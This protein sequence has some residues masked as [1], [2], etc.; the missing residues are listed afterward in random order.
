MTTDPLP[1]RVG[2]AGGARPRRLRPPPRR[3]AQRAARRRGAHRR[4]ARD[5]RP[6][7]SPRG[8]AS[9]SATRSADV[10][11]T[12]ELRYRGQAFELAVEAHDDA[13]E[14]REA[15]HAA[16]EEA[17]GFRDPEGEVEL[18]TL[19]ATATEPGPD[20]DAAAAGQAAAGAEASTRTA[21][22]GGEEHETAVLTRRAGAR[23]EDRGPGAGRAA[24]VHARRP[25]RLGGR[26]ARLRHDPAGEAVAI[27]PITL[28]V[29]SGALRAACEE[30][31]AVLVKA[32]AQRQHQGAPRRLLR[33]VRR[34]G[35][36]GHAGRA[37]PRAPRRDARRGRRGRRTRTTATARRGCSTTR[38]PAAPTC[39]T[40]PSSRPCSTAASC[41]ASPPAAPTTPTSAARRPA[42]CRPTRPRS[43]TRAS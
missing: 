6:A 2:R 20:V 31:G 18:V 33:A 42:R 28:R 14:L 35:P 16:H 38:S 9:S 15:F 3:P 8:R 36:D 1:A 12:A 21:I 4:G 10:R 17:Y 30:M 34:R 37:H 39:P 43:R 7:S 26:G 41:S 32:V 27:D 22:F 25:A 19:R 5:A 13:G 29:V 24:R 23:H 11:V 40:S